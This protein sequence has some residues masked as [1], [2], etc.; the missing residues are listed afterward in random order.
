MVGNQRDYLLENYSKWIQHQKGSS[1]PVI[2]SGCRKTQKKVKSILLF[3][4]SGK[5]HIAKPIC[6]KLLD[7][8]WVTIPHPLILQTWLLQS[9]TCTAPSPI[10][11]ARKNLTTTKTSKQVSSACMTKSFKASSNAGS[12]L[13]QSVEDSHR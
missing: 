10:I 3:H 9:I 13:Y 1:L 11:Y 12:L 6:E 7:L 5:F 4:D 8:R 2:G